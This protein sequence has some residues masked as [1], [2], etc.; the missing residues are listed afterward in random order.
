[1][2]AMVAAIAQFAREILRERVKAGIAQ[3]KARGT[4]I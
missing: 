3:A 4:F 2:A 1:M